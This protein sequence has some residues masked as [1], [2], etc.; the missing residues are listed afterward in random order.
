MTPT[1]ALPAA[2][3]PRSHK[4]IGRVKERAAMN[5]TEASYAQ[6]LDARKR[7]GEIRDYWFEAVTLKLAHDL[8]LTVD[9]FVFTLDRELHAI[10][11]KGAKKVTRK[12]GDRVTK[13]RIEEDARAKL[14]I[15]SRLFPFRFFTAHQDGG[16]WI[17]QEIPSA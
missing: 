7:V 12:S 5:R 14:L 3:R 13:P 8:R 11:T 1:A 17:E 9:F 10:D 6:Y 15:A 2:G 16:Q 4:A